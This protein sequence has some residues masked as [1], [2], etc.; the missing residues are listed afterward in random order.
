VFLWYNYI[1]FVLFLRSCKL[2][3]VS[4]KSQFVPSD[5][6]VAKLL[7]RQANYNRRVMEKL[8]VLQGQCGHVFVRVDSWNNHD[9]W[10]QCPITW[11][12]LYRCKKCGFE[13]TDT[14]V[15]QC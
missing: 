12:T 4:L 5:L 9:G 8:G 3:K 11:Y 15:S 14:S 13:R 2:E 1:S 6:V 7:W 10:S